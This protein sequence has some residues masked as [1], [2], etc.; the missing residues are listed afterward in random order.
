MMADGDVI[1]TNINVRQRIEIEIDLLLRRSAFVRIKFLFEPL[2][3]IIDKQKF[4]M[5]IIKNGT[6]EYVYTKLY[7]NKTVEF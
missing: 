2:T 1:T 5:S 3:M 4:A 7:E 6:I